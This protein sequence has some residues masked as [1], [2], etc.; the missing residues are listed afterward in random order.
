VVILIEEA[1]LEVVFLEGIT[2]FDE[3]VFRGSRCDG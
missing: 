3:E 2:I 1:P